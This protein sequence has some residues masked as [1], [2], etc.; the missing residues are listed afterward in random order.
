MHRGGIARDVILPDLRAAGRRPAGPIQHVLVSERYAVQRA[1]EHA[2]RGF[3]VRTLRLRTG[4]FRIE[5]DEA[6]QTGLQPLYPP[7]AGRSDLD[8]GNLPHPDGVGHADQ[9]HAG[10]SADRV[11]PPTLLLSVIRP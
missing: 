8:R 1:P 7:Y 11:I 9:T 5:C 2:L 6:V 3:P 4:I 10:R